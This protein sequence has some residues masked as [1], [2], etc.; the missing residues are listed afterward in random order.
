MPHVAGAEQWERSE[1][2]PGV[3]GWAALAFT[4]RWEL[5]EGFEQ[6]CVTL[7]DLYFNRN[8]LAADLR[9]DIRKTWAESGKP[10]RGLV[11]TSDERGESLGQG[12]AERVVNVVGFCIY[13]EGRG[14]RIGWSIACECNR[15]R[16][17]K[18]TL[19]L[20]SWMPGGVE[21]TLPRM[22][23]TMAEQSMRKC[24]ELSFGNVT[25]L[26]LPKAMH[27][28]AMSGAALFIVASNWKQPLSINRRMEKLSYIHAVEYYTKI[29]RPHW[30]SNFWVRKEQTADVCNTIDKSDRRNVEWKK[31]CM[32]GYIS[33]ALFYLLSGILPN[34]WIIQ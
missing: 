14:S 18:R 28:N 15:K 7:S 24:Q 17:I 8:I 32:K 22:G 30:E 21:L 16:R 12:V 26:P 1:W 13:F 6:R 20:S 25:S 31:T 4:L 23:K 11:S 2:W 33:G 5:L 19:M 10:V 3:W 27:R 29:Q 9:I 34:S